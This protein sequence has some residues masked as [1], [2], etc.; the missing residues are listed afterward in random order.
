V[1][2]QLLVD[3][4]Q[5]RFIE[6]RRLL[7]EVYLKKLISIPEACGLNVVLDFLGCN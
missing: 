2:V 1:C 7:L 3:H 6:K 4:L 5:T